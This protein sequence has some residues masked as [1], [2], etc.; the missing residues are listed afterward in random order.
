M[1][2]DVYNAGLPFSSPGILQTAVEGVYT[3]AVVKVAGVAVDSANKVAW[4][5]DAGLTGSFTP[6]GRALNGVATTNGGAIYVTT[7]TTGSFTSQGG[8]RIRS[9]GALLVATGAAGAT[10]TAIGGWL[11]TSTGAAR[12]SAVV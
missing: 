7:S 4:V 8:F 6:G 2:T 9:D 1:A 11:R 12:V 10:D 5:K 3:A